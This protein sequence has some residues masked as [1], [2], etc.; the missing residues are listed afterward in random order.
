M[1]KI[2]V[3]G[4]AGYIGS[5]VVK[6]LGE[7]GFDLIVVDD[8]SNGFR[9]AV[10]YGEFIEGDIGDEKTLEKVFENKISGVLHFAGSVIISESVENPSKYYENNTFNSFKLLERCIENNVLAF[11]FSSTAAVYGDSSS[12]LVNELDP[13]KPT[14]PYASS[15]LM[16]EK[17]I[18]DLSLS[19]NL[20]N[21]V[22]FR[23]FNVAGASSCGKLGQKGKNATHLMKVCAEV[24][25]GKREKIEVFGTDYETHDGTGVRDYIHVE[26]LA[27]LHVLGLKYLLSGK[28][29]QLFNCGYSKGASVK[30]V[31]QGFQ[32][33]TGEKLNVINGNRRAGDL[34]SLVADCTKVKNILNWKPEYNDLREIIKS[35]LEWE[36]KIN[37]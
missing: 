24:A 7:E 36:R 4:G 27:K 6:K 26:D 9:E 14:S 23:Y 34:A 19:S 29:S 11:V 10:T 32:E 33:I 22:I 1:G 21:Y 5:H 30:E 20:F 28:Q 17:M 3:T 8:L 15:K 31:I 12:K 13:V 16:T 18:K 35:A 37:D 2:L 25:S